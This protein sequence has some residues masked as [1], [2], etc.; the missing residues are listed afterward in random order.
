ME[1]RQMRK[2]TKMKKQWLKVVFTLTIILITVIGGV[3][4]WYLL[5]Q[6]NVQNPSIQNPVETT[7]TVPNLIKQT[8]T[9]AQAQVNTGDY[10]DIAILTEDVIAQI[11]TYMPLTTETQYHATTYLLEDKRQDYLEF[12]KTTLYFYYGD[13]VELYGENELP[14]VAEIQVGEAYKTDFTDE[15]T[16]ETYIAYEIQA[17]WNYE[18]NKSTQDETQQWSNTGSFTWIYDE[19]NMKWYLV[20]FTA[21]YDETLPIM[22]GTESNENV[23][24]D[25]E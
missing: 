11:F 22:Q 1:K 18:A 7:V 9:A 3:G 25:N 20:D 19:S 13:L 8:Q 12:L 16:Q 4:T 15:S 23:E 10:Q 14:K 24:A 17:T 21:E 6:S 2:K 5:N